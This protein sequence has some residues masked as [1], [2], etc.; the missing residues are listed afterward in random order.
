MGE[1]EKVE[2]GAAPAAGEPKPKGGKGKLIIIIVIILV[3]LLGGTIGGV[4]VYNKVLAP[5]LGLARLFGKGGGEEEKTVH[6]EEGSKRLGSMYPL[7]SFVVNLADKGGSRF[8]KISLQLEMS[9]ILVSEELGNRLPQIQDQVITVLSSKSMA[10]VSNVDGKF[11]LKTEI[12]ERINQLL[13]SGS[14]SNIFY[15]EFVVQ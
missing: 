3:V 1:E 6:K 13:V 12:M 15:T 10:D 2:E 11:K 14:I 9:D 7:P 4:I 5:S 8:I